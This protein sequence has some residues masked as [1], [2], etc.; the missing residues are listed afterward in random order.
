MKNELQLIDS[1]TQAQGTPDWINA[2]ALRAVTIGKWEPDRTTFGARLANLAFYSVLLARLHG[3]QGEPRWRSPLTSV[4]TLATAH[5]AERLLATG[6]VTTDEK[7]AP[8]INLQATKAVWTEAYADLPRAFGAPPIEDHG[9]RSWW[10]VRL[11]ATLAENFAVAHPEWAQA[12]LNRYYKLPEEER[13]LSL[14]LCKWSF[15]KGPDEGL[16]DSATEFIH[17]LYTRGSE[18]SRLYA[19]IFQ[20]SQALHIGTWVNW[21]FGVWLAVGWNKGL[22]LTE[23]SA[24]IGIPKLWSEFTP[25]NQRFTLKLLQQLEESAPDGV[26]FKQLGAGCIAYME[27]R[28]GLVQD[29][30]CPTACVHALDYGFWMALGVRGLIPAPLEADKPTSGE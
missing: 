14:R 21:K 10:F 17:H 5:F 23:E 16:E 24:Q 12:V 19:H 3:N 4:E 8:D 15:P 28:L 22:E 9:S 26:A 30:H 1:N 13:F 11:A 29:G 25:D 7:G 27:R 18:H 6:F 2:L 20:N